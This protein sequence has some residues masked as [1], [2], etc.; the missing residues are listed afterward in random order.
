M[1]AGLRRW[2]VPAGAALAVVLVVA[3]VWWS[4]RPGD[5]GPGSATTPP[6]ASAA[7]G[8]PG[9]DGGGDPAN[10]GHPD[11]PDGGLTPVPGPDS[12]PPR[13]GTQAIEG[14]FARD[15]RTLALNYATGVP[16]C[17][18]TVGKPQVEETASTVTV[19]LPK[20][21][22]KSDREVVCI[23]IAVLRSVDVT[24]ASPLGDREVRDGSRDGI[25]VPR[26]DAP[27]GD[28]SEGEPAY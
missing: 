20:T 24:L 25:Q 16:E 6:S 10:P 27:Y 3:V 5:A 13:A 9:Q 22:P 14:W 1:D 23:D 15:D 8:F 26:A 12:P 21:P 4:Q 28:G 2:L 19:T 7:P 17:Y 18:G 11:K